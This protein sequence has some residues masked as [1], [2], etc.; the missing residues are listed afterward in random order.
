MTIKIGISSCLLGE[1]VRF[2]GGHK[3]SAFCM[4]QLSEHV[5]Y[6]PVCPEMAIGMPAP[7]PAIR[8]QQQHNNQIHL[9]QSNDNSIDHTQA[10]LAFCDTKLPALSA[11]SGYIVCAKSPSCGMERVRLFD[12][13]GQQLGKLAVGLYTRQLMQKYPWLPIEEDGRLFDHAL[14]ENFICRVFSC[15]D[16]QQTMQHGFSVGKLVA[17]HSRYKFLV[18]A[19]SPT[20]YRE[21]GRL[22]ANAKFFAA[23]ELQQRYLLQLMQALKNIATRKQH[24]NVLQ[25][26]QGF[27]K[28]GL[29]AEAKQELSDL[30]HRYRQGFVPLLAPLTLLQHHLKQLPNAYVSN[31]RYFAPYPENL[32]LRA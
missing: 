24:T 29:A 15:Y 1:K 31:Q 18:M 13:T 21:L 30:I 2:D 28:H 11:L 12:A 16:Y 26:L 25:H 27:L 23:E 6:V 17:F 14:K 5:R 9:V 20:A 10:M 4:Q 3:G 8:L 7:R 32:G 19:H 22:V